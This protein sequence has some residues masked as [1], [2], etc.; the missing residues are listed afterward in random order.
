MSGLAER[1]SALLEVPAAESALKSKLS[2]ELLHS[3]TLSRSALSS[4]GFTLEESCKG[5]Y[6][7]LEETHG[8][9]ETSSESEQAAEMEHTRQM[10]VWQM[11]VLFK[12]CA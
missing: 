12:I 10:R 7:H 1:D 9:G 2:L 8:I 5:R 3:E 11:G 4:L 6:R